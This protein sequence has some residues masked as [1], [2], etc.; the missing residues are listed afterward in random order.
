MLRRLPLLLLPLVAL[1]SVL[2]A[3]DSDAPVRT[4]PLGEPVESPAEAAD[5]ALVRK[6][7]EAADKTPAQGKNAPKAKTPPPKATPEPAEDPEAEAEVKA[8]TA[9]KDKEKAKEKAASPSDSSDLA[10]DELDEFQL[11]EKKQVEEAK[12]QNKVVPSEIAERELKALREAAAKGKAEDKQGEKARA[13]AYQ[14]AI[15]EEVREDSRVIRKYKDEIEEELN[16]YALP[17][18]EEVNWN[19]LKK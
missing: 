8:E 9:A 3:A 15:R 18:S 11:F 7:M 2:R 1:P 16:E 14:E 12:N 10:T 13:K 19:G 5:A 4:S 6:V 17:D